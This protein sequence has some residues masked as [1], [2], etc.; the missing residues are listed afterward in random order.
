M[1]LAFQSILTITLVLNCQSPSE[2]KKSLT[3]STDF[4]GPSVLNAHSMAYDSNQ[5]LIYLFGGANEKEVLGDLWTFETGQNRWQKV[6]IEN[7]PTP[8]TFAPLVYDPI[9]D[10]LILFGGSKVLFGNGPDSS[11]LLNDTWE[12]KDGQWNEIETKGRPVPRAESALTYDQENRRIILFG[13]YKIEGKNYVKLGDT[14]EFSNNEWRQI[15]N[16]GP[17]PRHGVSTAYDS[18]NKRIV[19]FGGSTSD[20]QYGEQKGETWYLDNNEWKKLDIEQPPGVFNASM[21]Y[22]LKND[23]F[24]RFGG[25]NGKLRINETWSFRDNQWTQLKVDQMPEARNHAAMVYDP[26]ASKTILF[27]GHDGSNIFGDTWV[28]F[29]GNWSKV[30]DSGRLKRKE[31]GH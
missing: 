8:R 10:R 28:Y 19:L 30:S 21:V 7:G 22:D 27:G 11:N 23:E 12:F 17:S 6:A 5:S 29:D 13:G 4:E 26:S 16:D 1:K 15:A 18:K 2:Q 31:N 3:N 14:W 9:N 20:K 24:I 25:W